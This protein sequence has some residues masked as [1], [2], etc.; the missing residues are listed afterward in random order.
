MNADEGDL[1]DNSMC[2]GSLRVDSDDGFQASQLAAGGPHP[3]HAFF[4][5]SL[6]MNASGRRKK[7]CCEISE[8]RRPAA[9]WR[10]LSL[11]APLLAPIDSPSDTAGGEYYHFSRLEPG[12]VAVSVAAC[13]RS[14][15]RTQ[16]LSNAS[17]RNSSREEKRRF[18]KAAKERRGSSPFSGDRDC[19]TKGQQP[20]SCF[21]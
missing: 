21:R 18:G 13:R 8:F 14:R 2:D 19:R 15:S 3:L 7:K 20:F 17:C 10:Y 6:V 1:R 9:E 16:L 5:L 12:R 4:V 11:L